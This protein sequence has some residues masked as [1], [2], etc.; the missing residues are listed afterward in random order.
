MNTDKM[1]KIYE[2][3]GENLNEIIPEEWS[4]VVLYSEVSKHSST[5][6]FYFYPKNSN[7]LIYSLDIEDNYDIDED[8][9]EELFD[10]LDMELKS[11]YHEF[12][13]NKQKPW[14][15]LTLELK[16]DGEFNIDYDYSD[17]SDSDDYEQQIIW[18]YEKLGIY[19]DKNSTRDVNI[20]ETYK[21]LKQSI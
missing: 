11:L 8:A 18:K 16:S 10:S 17:L 15:N 19:P 3:I 4:R 12:K 9:L 5:T 13:S 14:T 6:Y 1:E 20:I 21:K 2:N 7:E